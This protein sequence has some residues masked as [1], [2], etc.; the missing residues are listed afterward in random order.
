MLV[1]NF[2]KIYLNIIELGI[3]NNFL[4][5]LLIFY[6]TNTFFFIILKQR[7]FTIIKNIKKSD[8]YYTKTIFLFHKI[9]NIFSQTNI[10]FTKIQKEIFKIRKIFI[11]N[12]IIIIK[13]SLNFYLMKI[14]QLFKLKKT[15]FISH[16]TNQINYLILKDLNS[17]IN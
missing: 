11:K 1:I 6:L 14:I 16:I 3:V 13:F 12:R 7:K 5:C 9:K 17:R 10:L 15:K 4:F 2:L 8:L